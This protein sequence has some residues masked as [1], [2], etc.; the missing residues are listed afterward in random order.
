MRR[1]INDDETRK[2]GERHIGYLETF[3]GEPEEWPCGHVKKLGATK[4]DVFSCERQEQMRLV[5]REKSEH[6]EPK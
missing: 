5:W 6:G 2:A 1:R 3:F 4:C